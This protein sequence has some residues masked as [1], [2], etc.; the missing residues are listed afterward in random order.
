MKF[1]EYQDLL[2]SEMLETVRNILITAAARLHM[3]L[4][5]EGLYT[6]IRPEDVG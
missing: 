4:Q 3:D 2:P 5:A 1:A 6:F